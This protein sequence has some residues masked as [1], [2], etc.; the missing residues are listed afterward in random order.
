FL[1][2]TPTSKRTSAVTAGLTVACAAGS[3]CTGNLSQGDTS[4]TV[5][6][7]DNGSTGVLTMSFTPDGIDCT[8]SEYEEHSSMLT[9][10]VTG[11]PRDTEVTLSFDTHLSEPDPSAYEVCFESNSDSEPS[12]GLLP[13]CDFESYYSTAPPCVESKTSEEGVVFLT[14]LVPA[15]DPK[16][17]I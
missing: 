2:L 17:R 6:G 3:D 15:G 16:G 12:P 14:F 5:T 11:G 9:Y 4:A 1:L 7:F 8:E 10:D 13:F